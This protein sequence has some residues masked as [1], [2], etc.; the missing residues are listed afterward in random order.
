MK[1]GQQNAVMRW[2]TDSTPFMTNGFLSIR[3]ERH[4]QDMSAKDIPAKQSHY[5]HPDVVNTIVE[6]TSKGF[7]TL[8]ANPSKDSARLRFEETYIHDSEATKEFRGHVAGKPITI[9]VGKRGLGKTSMINNWVMRQSGKLLGEDKHGNVIPAV[10]FRSDA[11]K[12]Y[13][14]WNDIQE[15][16]H[17]LHYH[18]I[19]AVYVFLTYHENDAAM[20]S[21]YLALKR[22]KSS[23]ERM[24]VISNYINKSRKLHNGQ[25]SHDDSENDVSVSIVHDMITD[26]DIAAACLMLYETIKEQMYGSG[27]ILIHI[28]DGIDNIAWNNDDTKYQTIIEEVADFYKKVRNDGGKSKLVLAARDETAVEIHKKIKHYQ[29]NV[30]S[31]NESYFLKIP[32][33]PFK[34]ILCRKIDALVGSEPF[35]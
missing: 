17:F 7:Q 13:D 22:Q 11:S 25:E 15:A 26:A 28:I 10:W 29:N 33:P 2:I 1:A 5:H 9:L 23:A 24:Q 12:I 32:V 34:E 31:G 16:S 18:T 21:V 3:S 4:N 27:V 20:Q 8:P 14:I 30:G 6:Y 35:K 19:H